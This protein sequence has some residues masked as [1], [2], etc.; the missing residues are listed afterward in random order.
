[1]A[2]SRGPAARRSAGRSKPRSTC[3]RDDAHAHR[4][5]RRL[6]HAIRVRPATA[7]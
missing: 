3:A 2:C 7:V 1:L 5:L 4:P 6:Y